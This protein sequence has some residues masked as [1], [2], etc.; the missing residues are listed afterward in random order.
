M[1]RNYSCQ[2]N[3]GTLTVNGEPVLAGLPETVSLAAG[4]AGS[5]LFLRFQAPAAAAR[6]IYLTWETWS[7][8]SALPA[9]TAM[10]RTGCGRWQVSAEG[11]SRWRL[12]SC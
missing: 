9:A 12:N 1:Q 2:L 11:R 4:E 6:Q 7:A 3:G 10:S 5:G 8:S